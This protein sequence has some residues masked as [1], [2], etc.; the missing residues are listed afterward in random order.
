MRYVTYWRFSSDKTGD[1]F[2]FS[3]EE[4]AGERSS[5]GETENKST[6]TRE[7]EEGK[8]VPDEERKI[9]TSCP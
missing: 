7:E 5:E 9:T 2:C 4:E 6:K 8:S 3:G 1:W